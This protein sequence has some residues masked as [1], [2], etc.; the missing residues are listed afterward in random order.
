LSPNNNF[1][2]KDVLDI[3]AKITIL[4]NELIT[5]ELNTMSILASYMS[6]EKFYIVN[7]NLENSDIVHTG[8]VD[9]PTPIKYIDV[10]LKFFMENFFNGESSSVFWEANKHTLYILRNANYSHV[11]EIFKEMEHINVDVVRG[12]VQRS[13]VVSP[14]DFRLSC[15][16]L[17][18]FNLNF[19][20]FVME[21][22][23]NNISKDRFLPVG[24][25]TFYKKSS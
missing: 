19:N 4:K 14:I 1:R 9:S 10:G 24:K 5:P 8:E 12:S 2:N 21:N 7:I 25:E 18:L 23:F 3:T 13:H 11:K 17:L 15:Y 6:L 22:S 20:K 16:M